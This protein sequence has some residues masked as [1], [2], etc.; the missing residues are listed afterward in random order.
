MRMRSQEHMRYALA[1]VLGLYSVVAF[2]TLP[3]QTT[4][5]QLASDSDHILAGHV[6]GVDMIGADG[7]P[8]GAAF[9][10]GMKVI[11]VVV[12]VILVV[13]WARAAQR[14]QMRRHRVAAAMVARRRVHPRQPTAPV[15]MAVVIAAV[16][17]VVAAVAID[18]DGAAK[19]VRGWSSVSCSDEE[20]SWFGHLRTWRSF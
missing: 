5:E 15:S 12:V 8:G 18:G 7:N 9:G 20:S 4:L 16:E 1:L 13:I 3:L 11:F 17:T 2:A 6:I 14:R 19:D 10:A